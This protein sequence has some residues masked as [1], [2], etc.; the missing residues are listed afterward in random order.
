MTALA[1]ICTILIA[2][3]CIHVAARSRGQ[4]VAEYMVDAIYRWAAVWYALAQAADAALCRYRR[5]RADIRSAHQPM[6]LE[7]AE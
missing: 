7:M 2:A 1:I 4:A 5:A 3:A 6:Y